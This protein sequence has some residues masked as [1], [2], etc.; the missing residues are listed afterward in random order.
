MV[1]RIPSLNNKVTLSKHVQT[2]IATIRNNHK[3]LYKSN[4]L[5]NIAVSTT[6]IA[7]WAATFH[8]AIFT[9]KDVTSLEGLILVPCMTFLYTGLFITAHDAMHENITQ[10]RLVNDA[11]GHLCS[12]LYAG[13]DFHKM[14]HKHM[15]HHINTGVVREDPDFHRGKT[16][17]IH[18]YFSFMREYIDVLQMVKLAVFIEALK[19]CGASST[20]IYVYMAAC[21]ILSSLQLFYF[22]TYTPHKP[23]Q[24]HQGEVMIWEKSNSASKSRIESLLTSYHFDCHF[25]H[26]AMPQIPWFEL[27]TFKNEIDKLDKT[28]S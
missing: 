19:Y 3:K 6:V 24:D 11:I 16:D 18:W 13:M 28:D 2:R 5:K 21:G 22:G 23:P 26:H 27:W 10:N 7:G 14:R 4:E 8:E 20:N 15:L 17:F 25:E 9:V 1:V 12:N